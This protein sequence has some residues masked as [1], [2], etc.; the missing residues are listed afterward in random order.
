MAAEETNDLFKQMQDMVPRAHYE[1][2]QQKLAHG[3]LL[4][5]PSGEGGGGR[6]V[7]DEDDLGVEME[8]EEDEEKVVLAPAGAAA[9]AEGEGGEGAQADRGEGG[10]EAKPKEASS[11]IAGGAER[12]SEAKHV[13]Q[14]LRVA[15]AA[16]RQKVM[17][18]SLTP[19]P[20]WSRMKPDIAG[21]A[22]FVKGKA[23]TTSG[24]VTKLIVLI[25]ELQKENVAIKM[26]QESLIA[27]PEVKQ[28]GEDD[29]DDDDV[30][31]ATA[32]PVDKKSL[33]EPAYFGSVAK[34]CPPQHLVSLRFTFLV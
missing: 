18:P 3:S 6:L 12:G 27:K 20:A 32:S 34:P 33:S 28:R 14:P 23:E 1:A 4:R 21:P 9:A 26:H 2:L 15:P 10:E 16:V 17:N 8:E 29:D 13:D 5:A 31:V 24:Y 19:R 7:L 25:R 22:N 11:D 30:Q